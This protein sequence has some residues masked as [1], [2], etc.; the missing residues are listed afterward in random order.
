M[1]TDNYEKKIKE[2]VKISD[3]RYD[4]HIVEIEMFTRYTHLTGRFI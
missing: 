1:D 4:A 2:V 3:K